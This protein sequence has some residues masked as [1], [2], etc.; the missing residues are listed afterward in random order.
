[1]NSVWVGSLSCTPA[2]RVGDA[3][4]SVSAG[5]VGGTKVEALSFEVLVT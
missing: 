5:L 3:K 4:G 1:M 2:S